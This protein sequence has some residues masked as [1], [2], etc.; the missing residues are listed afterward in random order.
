[1]A[2]AQAA[3]PVWF[4]QAMTNKIAF[5]SDSVIRVRPGRRL[6]VKSISGQL[7]AQPRSR[8]L[9]VASST[10]RTKRSFPSVDSRLSVTIVSRPR[11]RRRCPSRSISADS[12]TRSS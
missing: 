4:G 9:R 5:V 1:M 2:V 12:G 8:F 7:R 10:G 11:T 6:G 3:T